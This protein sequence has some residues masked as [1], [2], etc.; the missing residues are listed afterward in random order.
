MKRHRWIKWPLAMLP[1]VILA[2]FMVGGVALATDK[3]S[4]DDGDLDIGAPWG[5]ADQTDPNRVEVTYTVQASGG[6]PQVAIDAVNDGIQAWIKAINKRE[7]GWDFDIV[8]YGGGSGPSGSFAGRSIL[9]CHKG[10]NDSKGCDGGGDGGDDDKADI[11]IKLKKGGGLVAGQALS[12]FD[13]EGY[14]VGVK[15][16]ISGSAFGLENDTDTITEVTM[17]ELGHA[18]GLGH[19]SNEDDL[20]GRTVGH[21]DATGTPFTSISGCD[22]DGF[23]ESHH[24]LTNDPPPHLNHVTSIDC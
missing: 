2:L 22:L 20:M 12:S 16:Q 19:H 23:E 1:I 14:R 11:E 10:G 8:P 6:V 21:D 24:W 3:P 17:H 9:A 7:A 5:P 13:S 15:I 18:L 4:H